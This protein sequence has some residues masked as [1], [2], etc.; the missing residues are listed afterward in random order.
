MT[1][2]LDPIPNPDSPLARRDPR[3]RLAAVAA[4]IVTVA[5]LQTVPAAAAALVGAVLLAVAAR[6]PPRWYARRLAGVAPFLVLCVISL[7]FLVPDPEPLARLGPLALSGRGLRLAVLVG[8]KAVAVLTLA[9][10]VLV[11]APLPVTLHAAYALRVPG[12]LVHLTL[13]SYRYVGLLAGELA[14]VRVALRVRGYRNRA[15]RHSYR[16]VAHVAAG[17]LVRGHDRAERVGQAMRSRGFDGR[18]RSLAAFRTTP[19]DVLVFLAVLAAAGALAG[20]DLW[21]RRGA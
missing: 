18:F 15:T 16:T 8:L 14:R 19:A 3:W 4:A 5:A 10:V 6:M 2:S 13:L 11:S 12:L 20:W 1:L 21:A 7:P 9:W 17:L